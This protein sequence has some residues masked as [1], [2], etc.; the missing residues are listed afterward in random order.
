MLRQD[1]AEGIMIDKRLAE[2]IL[3]MGSS[4]S[5]YSRWRLAEGICSIE[6]VAEGAIA[7]V[8]VVK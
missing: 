6:L 8:I 4:T 3:P 2:G 7:E 1:I 5:G